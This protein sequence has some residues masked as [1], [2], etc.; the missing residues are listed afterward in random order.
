MTVLD[1][2]LP[3]VTRTWKT[4]RDIAAGVGQW[5]PT[6][7]RQTLSKA[8]AAG[9]VE[10]RSVPRPHAEPGATVWQYRAKP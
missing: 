1:D 8:A 7:I 10:R 3:H 4:A 6:S 9:L 5:S 2:V